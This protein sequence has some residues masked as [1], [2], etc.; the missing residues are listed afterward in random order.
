MRRTPPPSNETVSRVMRRMGRRNT[1]PELAL[2]REL[3]RLGLRYRLHRPDL[4]G[5]P[6][7][8]FGPAR[9][10]VF[11][12]GCFWHSCPDHGVLPKA[13]RDWWAVKL[14]RNEERDR[15]KDQALAAAGWLAVHVW[16]HEDPVPAARAIHATVRQRR[17]RGS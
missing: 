17:P 7:I 10:A 2:R 13:N 11:V 5:R 3:T 12:D 15:Q 14:A 4:P 16:E 1:A 6:D 9:V 8:C